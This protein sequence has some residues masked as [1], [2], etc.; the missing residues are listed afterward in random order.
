[1]IKIE[2]QGEYTS[3]NISGCESEL[4]NDCR[5]LIQSTYINA[6]F[7]KVFLEAWDSVIKEREN[8]ND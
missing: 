1:M 6:D 7:G 4:F 3:T 2:K 8:R 5:A